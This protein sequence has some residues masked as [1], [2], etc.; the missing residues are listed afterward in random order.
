MWK[1]LFILL[2]LANSLMFFWYAQQRAS[3]QTFVDTR[4][5]AVQTI[6]LVDDN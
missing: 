5:P 6:E 2:L 3:Q 1:W 4:L